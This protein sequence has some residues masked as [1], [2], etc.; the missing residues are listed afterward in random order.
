MSFTEYHELEAY[1]SKRVLNIT[2]S[3]DKKATVWQGIICSI[4]KNLI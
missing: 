1:Y 2:K 3:L 4:I